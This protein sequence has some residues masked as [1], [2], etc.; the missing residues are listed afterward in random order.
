MRSGQNRHSMR[1]N[2][3][4]CVFFA[5]IVASLHQKRTARTFLARFARRQHHQAILFH[6]PQYHGGFDVGHA[7]MA[8]H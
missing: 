6:A 1:K 3:L 5:F 7:L 4:R 8:R 2:P